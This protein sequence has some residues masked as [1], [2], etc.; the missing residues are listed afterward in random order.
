MTQ[1]VMHLPN[2]CSSWC[3]CPPAR[4]GVR[5]TSRCC[6]ACYRFTYALWV[7]GGACLEESY[8]SFA[9]KGETHDS[10]NLFAVQTEICLRPWL[11][12]LAISLAAFPLNP[13]SL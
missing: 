7:L 5:M 12:P 8:S 9:L 3:L 2:H 10:L 1:A 4:I 6:R 11:H 13:C